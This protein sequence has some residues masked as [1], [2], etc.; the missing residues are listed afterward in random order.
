MDNAESGIP[1]FDW[2]SDNFLKTNP[3]NC[4]LLINTDEN[5]TLK[6]INETITKSSNKKLLGILFDNTFD[7]RYDLINFNE[8]VTSSCRKASQKLNSL[9]RVAHYLNLAQ[10]RSIM[11]ASFRNLDLGR[12]DGCFIIGN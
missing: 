2:F 11:N 6:I 9:A 4:H 10:C 8:H 12:W 5:V 7:N 3:D 1:H